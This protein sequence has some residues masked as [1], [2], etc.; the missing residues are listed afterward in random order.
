MRTGGETAA[1]EDLLASTRYLSRCHCDWGQGLTVTQWRGRYHGPALG[2]PGTARRMQWAVFCKP[3]GM[4]FPGK[5]LGQIPQ[6]VRRINPD[7]DRGNAL[8]G[9]KR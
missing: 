6:K 7:G 8:F 2:S 1:D 9:T 5:T 3:H 4:A